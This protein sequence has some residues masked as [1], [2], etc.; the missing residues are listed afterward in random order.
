MKTK[1]LIKLIIL[2]FSI[3]AMYADTDIYN[4]IENDNTS[5]LFHIEDVFVSKLSDRVKK[6]VNPNIF[7]GFIDSRLIYLMN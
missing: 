3:A 6:K 1:K 5:D 7:V 2:T 4:Q